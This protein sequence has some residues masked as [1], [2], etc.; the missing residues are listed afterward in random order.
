MSALHLILLHKLLYL[1]IF[2]TLDKS[3]NYHASMHNSEKDHY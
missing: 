1:S 2:Q 3:F